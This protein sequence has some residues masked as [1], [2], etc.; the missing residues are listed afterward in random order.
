MPT[1]VL[2]TA[3]A[4]RAPAAFRR[5]VAMEPTDVA[6]VT[7]ATTLGSTRSGTGAFRRSD[8]TSRGCRPWPEAKPRNWNAMT[9]C[10]SNE[11]R[12]ASQG[13][14]N[15]KNIVILP[16]DGNRTGGYCAP[17]EEKWPGRIWFP[18]KARPKLREGL[19]TIAANPPRVPTSRSATTL[20]AQASLPP[21]SATEPPD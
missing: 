3:I 20:R 1:G 13:E 6:G 15:H 17:L 4:L 5:P 18:P 11:R 16:A 9:R 19:A 12:A 14:M 10:A 21:T 2:M 7:E 8:G